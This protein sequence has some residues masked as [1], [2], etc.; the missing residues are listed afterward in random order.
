MLKT[1]RSGDKNVGKRNKDINNEVLTV[2][3]ICLKDTKFI[4]QYY[5]LIVPL[6]FRDSLYSDTEAVKKCFVWLNNSLWYNVSSPKFHTPNLPAN[7]SL[8]FHSRNSQKQLRIQKRNAINNSTLSASR[9]KCCSNISRT[10]RGNPSTHLALFLFA[11]GILCIALKQSNDRGNRV[12]AH[13]RLSRLFLSATKD[14][15]VW[16][17]I[18]A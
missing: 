6:F 11:R 4:L 17:E 16:T 10:F 1:I 13:E 5:L 2:G 14:S 9:I 12:S 7:S 3:D 8:G 15:F 18:G